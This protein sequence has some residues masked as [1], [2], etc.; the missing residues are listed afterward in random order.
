MLAEM[1]G[2]VGWYSTTLYTSNNNTIEGITNVGGNIGGRRGDLS[3]LTSNNNIIKGTT[4]VGGNIGASEYYN[5]V[6]TELV[7]TGAS[8]QISG[9]DKI[10]GSLGILNARL[11]YVK[12]TDASITGTG[13][14]VGGIVGKSEYTNTSIPANNM[15]NYTIV[16]VYAKDLRIICEGNNV[17]GIVGN[18]LGTIY[19]SVAENCIVNSNNGNN[20][21]GIVGYY[22]GYGG[23]SGSQLSSSNY[24]L[25]HSYCINSEV[26]AKNNAGGIVGGF[27]FGN[28]QYTYVAN[29]NITAINT[30]AG[31]IVGYFDN[32]KL[33]NLQYKGTIKYN[34][35]ANVDESK[36][37]SANN[38][39]GGLVGILAKNLNYDEDIERYNNIECNL[40]VTDLSSYNNFV[41]F[42]AG[43]INN[44][45]SALSQSQYMNNIYVYN[46]S[47][48]N[49]V[50]VGLITKEAD[51]YKLIS[52]EDL[53]KN[54]TFTK[55]TAIKDEEGETI[56]YDGLNFGTSR[57]VLNSGYFPILT[58]TYSNA[59]TYWASNY[60]NI[61]Q[62]K[63]PIP[64]RT[65]QTR[66]L[67]T[68]SLNTLGLRKTKAIVLETLPETYLYPVD[69][70]K[71]NIEFSKLGET[72]TFSVFANDEAIIQNQKIDSRVYTLKYDFNTPLK[73]VTSNVNY[74]EELEYKA[75]EIQNSLAI[76]NNEYFYLLNNKLNSNKRT[77][78]GE[79]VNIFNNK[80]LDP[81]GN[82]YELST[83]DLLEN[84]NIEIQLLEDIIP[85]SNSE[86]E[87]NNILTFYHCSKIVQEDGEYTFKDNQLF[88]KDNKLYLID[89]KLKNKGNSV[90]INSYN[91]NQYEATLGTD[92][93]IYDLLSKINYPDNFKNKDIVQMTNNI[94]NDLNIVLVSY[95]NGNVIGFNYITGKEVYNNNIGEKESL[96]EYV[97]ENFNLTN[98][99]YE[100]NNSDY[101]EANNLM[102]KLEKISVE[103]AIEKA[104]D[105]K[106][107]ENIILNNSEVVSNIVDS[108]EVNNSSNNETIAENTIQN[109]NEISITKSN[110]NET[111][112]EKLDADNYQST[113]SN[114][115]NTNSKTTNNLENTYITAYEPISQSYVIYNTKELFS[116]NSSRTASENEKIKNNN[117]IDFYSNVSV[118]KYEIKNIGVV[119]ITVI[120]S[121]IGIILIIM[122]KKS[123]R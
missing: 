60:L 71:I 68:S 85:I 34:Y 91:D 36:N 115:K 63:I 39:V 4:N 95:S 74:T 104:S 110:A 116:M 107:S 23:T 99:L 40:I 67:T 11:R 55:N 43:S 61:I 7:V 120:L 111:S 72:S 109:N 75:N 73:I 62:S 45:A 46:C 88:V 2:Y 13:S 25:W 66:A 17:G 76:Y 117:L 19:A 56:G 27:V 98:L 123:N 57:Y 9:K 32:S 80:A 12:V 77:F 20:A 82:I 28:I 97:K 69:I 64:N 50:Q 103:D 5:S 79:Y 51:S 42:G 118:N 81:E 89:G 54:S 47:Y 119:I 8:T 114:E 16:G 26:R 92:G 102:K 35:V 86:F 38:S 83:M 108:N 37:I 29:T 100:I 59:T 33:N 21:G 6:Y 14:N 84:V 112:Q 22:T 122:Y 90:I 31:G 87:N 24:Y 121:T 101:E 96:A 41:S 52:S 18:A 3:K 49:G 58:T 53:S 70:D 44:T 48:L 93:V 15:T 113:S 65:V 94:D 106:E 10:G 30:G 105:E 78:D 1:V